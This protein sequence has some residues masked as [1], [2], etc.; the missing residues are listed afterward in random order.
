MPAAAKGERRRAPDLL[1]RAFAAAAPNRRGWPTCN[2][3]VGIRSPMPTLGICRQFLG[4][5]A[6]V[7]VSGLRVGIVTG[8]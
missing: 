6:P 3:D 2:A 8:M 1:D 4:W 5:R 7:R